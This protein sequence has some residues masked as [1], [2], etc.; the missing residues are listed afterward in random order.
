MRDRPREIG[1]A[2]VSPRPDARPKNLIE[3]HARRAARA[4]VT[5]VPQATRIRR[6]GL[7]GDSG[8]RGVLAAPIRGTRPGCGLVG[9]VHVQTV[10][11]VV[12]SPPAA[13]D[14]ATARALANWVRGGL[15]PAVG[16]HGG[17]VSEISVAGHYVCRTRNHRP[18][19]PI[20]EHGRGRA[21]DIS[22]IRLENGAELRVLGGWRDPNV[23]PILKQAHRAACGV[24]G[25]VLG[26][27]AD[28]FHR[29]HFHFD[30][31]R[32]RNG[33]YCR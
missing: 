1:A 30:T 33:A 12:L 31:A 17:G 3:R 18:G 27:N 2:T 9:G 8:L 32:H 6:G 11:D 15:K 13:M 19:A 26:P 4:G 5:V 10:E 29:D 28:R 20:S 25:T 21:I 24:F 23:G 16:K 14:C 22:A 7:C